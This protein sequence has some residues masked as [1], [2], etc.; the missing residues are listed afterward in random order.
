MQKQN[1]LFSF[2]RL[3]AALALGLVFTISVS[4]FSA[5]ARDCDG[6]R[7]SVL[8]LHILANSDSDADQ[9][10]KLAVRDK[11]L[12]LDSRMFEGAQSLSEAKEAALQ[13]LELVRAAALEEIRSQGYDYNV[14]VE[15][16][17]MY[18]STREYDAFTLP[19]GYYDALRVTIGSGKGHNWWCVLYPPLCLPAAE[20]GKELGDVLTD[21]ELAIVEGKNEYRFRFALVELFEKIKG[22]FQGTV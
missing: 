10:L 15:L 2:G 21:E 1:G 16:A 22:Y 7:K 12:A 9:A 11:I 6:I 17:N 20:S 8:R 4:S 13:Q 14:S 5:F 3:M 18:F 19:A